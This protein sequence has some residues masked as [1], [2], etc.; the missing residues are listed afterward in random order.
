MGREGGGAGGE[1]GRYSLEQLW[2]AAV[3]GIEDLCL[4]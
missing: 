3:N 2:F 1:E 4:L